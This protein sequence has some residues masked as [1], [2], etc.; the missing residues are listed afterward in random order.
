MHELSVASEIAPGLCLFL[1]QE[2]P[3]FYQ[4]CNAQDVKN[5]KLTGHH[6]LTAQVQSWMKVH[7]IIVT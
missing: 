2:S 5:L 4:Q 6:M 3:L 1:D 7:S